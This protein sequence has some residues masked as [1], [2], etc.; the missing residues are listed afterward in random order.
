VSE[1]YARVSKAVGAASTRFHAL[2]HYHGTRAFA[3]GSDV[4]TVSKRLGHSDPS[5][6]LRIYAHAIEQRDRELAAATGAELAPPI[7][8][9]VIPRRPRPRGPRR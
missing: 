9:A 4:V 8:P 1:R 7:E 2:R 3:H 5:I 6:T